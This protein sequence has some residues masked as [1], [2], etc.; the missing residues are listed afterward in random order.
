MA[1][2]PELPEWKSWTVRK[3]WTIFVLILDIAI[4]VV[5][6]VLQR[7][8]AT[9]NGIAKVPATSVSSL[10]N[11]SVSGIVSNAGLL[12]TTLPSFLMGLNRLAWDS[13]ISGATDR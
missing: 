1:G 7:L 8:S 5:I 2:V 10:S 6:F 4:V 12:W 9:Q 11:P 13:I 3:P